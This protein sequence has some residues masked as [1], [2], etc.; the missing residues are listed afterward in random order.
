[1]SPQIQLRRVGAAPTELK[2]SIEDVVPL[3][4][5]YEFKDLE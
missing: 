5:W 4:V 2:I 3:E 1:M